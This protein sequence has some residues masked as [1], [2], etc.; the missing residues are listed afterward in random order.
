MIINTQTNINALMSIV[1]IRPPIGQ[2]IFQLAF[3]N[4]FAT[5][6]VLMA[7][8]VITPFKNVAYRLA[9]ELDKIKFTKRK[10]KKPMNVVVSL[11]LL[12]L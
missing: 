7:M 1:S 10:D 2:N 5:I 11:L 4:V 3:A 6:P 8:Y 12:K 9:Q